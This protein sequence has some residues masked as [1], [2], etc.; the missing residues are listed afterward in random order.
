MYN[1]PFTN[2]FESDPTWNAHPFCSSFTRTHP[3]GPEASPR[4][5]EANRPVPEQLARFA[6]TH[7]SREPSR[8]DNRAHQF[9]L[10][11]VEHEQPRVAGGR[12]EVL[13][14][15]GGLDQNAPENIPGASFLG[16]FDAV[17]VDDLRRRATQQRLV[18]LQKLENVGLPE[19]GQRTVLTRLG[20]SN[21][22]RTCEDSRGLA[23]VEAVLRPPHRKPATT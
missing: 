10:A 11:E 8:A 7:Q 2:S 13:L 3:E 5:P 21:P 6:R 22:T 23:Y 15:S 18:Q 9:E 17:Q 16:E 12:K 20:S 19:V 4:T 1:Y 14:V